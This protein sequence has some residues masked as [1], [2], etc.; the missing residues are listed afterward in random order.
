[1]TVVL[2]WNC[3]ILKNGEN[4]LFS[5]SPWVCIIS[6]NQNT[7]LTVVLISVW[8]ICRK[9]EQAMWNRQKKIDE[10][11]YGL[12]LESSKKQR[13]REK[14]KWNPQNMYVICSSL[15]EF[16]SIFLRSCHFFIF[17]FGSTPNFC[18]FFDLLLLKK[19]AVSVCIN[20]I[21]STC[22]SHTPMCMSALFKQMCFGV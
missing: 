15:Q 5:S 18:S 3:N 2:S 1:M 22:I 4:S 9:N 6:F 12:Q 11:N 16:V 13:E 19:T 14:K 17:L 8:K 21:A 7:L 10:K 20:W